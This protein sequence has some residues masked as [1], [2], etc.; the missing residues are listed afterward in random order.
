MPTPQVQ[1]NWR[2]RLQSTWSGSL[3][4]AYCQQVKT[5]TEI[6]LNC[7]EKDRDRRPGISEIILRLNEMETMID[8]LKNDA[9]SP[10]DEV[11]NY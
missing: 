9:E 1:G 4:E 3:L 11:T 10:L 8:E 2:N 7:M 6:A 5:C